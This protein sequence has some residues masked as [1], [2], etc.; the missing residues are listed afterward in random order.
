MEWHGV[1]VVGDALG[2]R[3]VDHI[4]NNNEEDD[5]SDDDNDVMRMMIVMMGEGD[6]DTEDGEGEADENKYVNDDDNECDCLSIYPSIYLSLD[7]VPDVG[8]V[9]AHAKGDGRA[10]HYLSI[11]LSLTRSRT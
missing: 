5:D 2:Q 8:F 1:V 7:H 6:G 10:Q 4:S 9:D 11:Y 3:V